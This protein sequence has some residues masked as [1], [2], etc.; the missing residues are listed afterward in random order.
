M[1]HRT[2]ALMVNESEQATQ[3]QEG[4]RTELAGLRTQLSEGQ[5]MGAVIQSVE[6]NLT[7]KLRELQS[8][9]AQK[10]LE[11]DRRDAEF[12]EIKVQLQSLAQ[13]VTQAGARPSAQ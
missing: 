8:Q 1:A 11:A 10:M 5:S 6:D 7:V 9:F 13:R 3:V 4:L 2:H 12:R